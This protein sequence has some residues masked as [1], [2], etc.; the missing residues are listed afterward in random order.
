MLSIK[1]LRNKDRYVKDICKRI[2]TNGALIY[3]NMLKY[4]V[5]KYVSCFK[6]EKS[7][8]LTYD[9][10]NICERKIHRPKYL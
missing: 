4:L 9:M 7:F 2:N 1:K 5:I 8:F 3:K 6:I 10:S